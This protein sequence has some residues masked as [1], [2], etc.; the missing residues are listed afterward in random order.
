MSEHFL[1]DDADLIIRGGRILSVDADDT[2]L[3]AI[4]VV[5]GRT[6]FARSSLTADATGF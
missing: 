1:G 3:R 6:M 5:G 2:E 4:A